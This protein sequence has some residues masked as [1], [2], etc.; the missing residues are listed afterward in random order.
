M[1][2]P[3]ESIDLS[4]YRVP[5]LLNLRSRIEE[6]LPSTEIEDLDLNAEL[7]WTFQTAKGLLEGV[8]EET[9]L[10]QKASTVN[11]LTGILKTLAET[12]KSLYSAERQQKLERALI[13]A[14]KK[15]PELQ[16]A[17]F[18]EYEGKGGEGGENNG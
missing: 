3:V 10:T 14:L 6:R 7:I 11:S 1:I 8:N 2:L 12:Q 17:F 18:D 9:P 5:D 4:A 15:F 16:E 13:A